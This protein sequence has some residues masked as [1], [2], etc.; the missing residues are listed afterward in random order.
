MR[1]PSRT[2]LLLT[3]LPLALAGCISLGPDV[4]D[5]LLVLT[6]RAAP[7]AGTSTTGTNA[8]AIVVEEPEAEQRIGV[9]R[10]P[11]QV[12]DANVAYLQDAQWVDRPARLF[13]GLLAETLRQRTG[14]V[15]IDGAVIGLDVGTRLRGTIREFGYD[16]RTSS[17]VVTFDA[18]RDG[19]GGTLET[20]RFSSTVPGIAA[21]AAPV[22][23]ALNRAANDV[24]IDVAE[25]IAG[26]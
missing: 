21:E 5:S 10:V 23:D 7:M 12:D 16:A 20:R 18:V 2:A 1:L 24:A 13:R 14:R 3:G 17:V 9:T 4:P 25:W 11:V 19:S 22:G 8:T 26:G 6:A 15:V